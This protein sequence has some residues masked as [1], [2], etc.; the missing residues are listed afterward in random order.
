[1]RRVFYGPVRP[2]LGLDVVVAENAHLV[3]EKLAVCPEETAV[4][5]DW[6]EEG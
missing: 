4:E 5:R 6:R 2:E 1:M 3:R